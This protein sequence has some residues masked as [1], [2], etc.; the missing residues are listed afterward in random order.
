[1]FLYPFLTVLLLTSAASAQIV[2]E[3][4]SFQAFMAGEESGAAYD[5]WISHVVEG[6]ARPG[7]NVYAPPALDPQLNG[8]GAFEIL[9]DDAAGDELLQLFADLADSLLAG[10]ADGA[11]AR[12]Q[13]GPLTDYELVRFQD[14]DTGRELLMLRESLDLSYTD[15]GD[16]DTAED[17]VFGSFHHGWGLFV[18]SP[19]ATRPHWMVQAPH[20]NDDYP[21]PYMA[22]DLFQRH[23]AGLLMINGAGREVAYTGGAADYTNGESLSDPT[24]NCR[25]PFAVIHERVV[26]HYR[27]QGEIERTIQV[28]SYD[29]ASHRDLKSCVVSDGRYRRLHSQPLLDGGDGHAG[30]FNNLL[31]PMFPSGA[32]GFFH[33]AVNL[34]EYVAHQAWNTFTVDGGT[35]G[36]SL[37]LYISASLWGHPTSCQELYSH[38]DL[39]DGTTAED[40]IHV[41]MDELPTLAHDLGENFWYQ[42]DGSVADWSQFARVRQYYRPLFDALAV[43]EDSLTAGLPGPEPTQVTNLQV[44]EIDVDRLR[45]AWTPLKSSSFESYEILLDP[46]GELTENAQILD[47]GDIHQLCWPALNWVDVDGLDYQVEYAIALRGRDRQGRRGAL[48]DTLRAA[49]DDLLP[50]R[51]IPDYPD[52]HSR[53]WIRPDG[54][55]VTVRVL[56]EDHLVDLSSLEWR[57]DTNM[58]GAYDPFLEFWHT[59][60]LSGTGAS[61]LVDIAMPEPGFTGFSRIEFRAHDDQHLIWGCSGSDDECGIDDDWEIGVDPD[62]PMAFAGTPAVQI[63][64][65]GGLRIVWDGQPSDSTFFSHQ[66]ALDAGE[67]LDFESASMILDRRD[68]LSL[69]NPAIHSLTL[70]STWLPGSTLN[71]RLRVIDAAGNAGPA[72]ENLAFAYWNPEFCQTELEVINMQDAWLD[73]AWQSDCTVEGLVV[74]GWWLHAMSEPWEAPTEENRL[75]FVT[76][77]PARVNWSQFGGRA[78]FQLIPVLELAPSRD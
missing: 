74:T 66:V 31:Q 60:D 56:D 51:F 25:H 45:L 55:T 69:G 46:S 48:S 42:I 58:N 39:A 73:L 12:L 33:D 24:R 53:F 26:E 72:S 16:E 40:W 49:P 4:G 34:Q 64:I 36:Q 1:M 32:F 44:T 7:Y 61:V 8:F 22:V 54:G 14:S 27:G 11:L 19:E 57:M 3:S 23:D 17:D 67:I 59:T 47:F 41:E 28:H 65:D 13:T 62:P 5:N 43:A 77:S 71:L 30:L 37:P 20:P 10:N 78:F 9:Q 21:S 50:P 52:G 29:D 18:F 75:E 6:V 68:V 76:A 63:P 35:P 70:D 38:D 2:E 15:P